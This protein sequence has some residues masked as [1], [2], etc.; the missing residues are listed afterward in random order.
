MFDQEPPRSS[1]RPPGMFLRARTA[2]AK[3]LSAW[4][5]GPRF[6]VLCLAAGTLLAF[7]F[8]GRTGSPI[9]VRKRAFERVA[10]VVNEPL[11]ELVPFHARI[12]PS[13]EGDMVLVDSVR[14]ACLDAAAH[15]KKIGALTFPPEVQGKALDSA[16]AVRSAAGRFV[17]GIRDCP[18]EGAMAAPGPNAGPTCV[19]RC[20]RG[21]SSLVG[22]AERLREDAA[23]LGVR[24]QPIAPGPVQ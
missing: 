2:D 16:D 7:A 4:A 12:A 18:G 19:L 10:Q 5:S 8:G 22:S 9:D 24:V 20:M 14:E 15:V 21:W 3:G 1:R 13:G 6:V 17:E 23:W 11:R